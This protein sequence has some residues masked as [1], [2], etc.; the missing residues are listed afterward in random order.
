MASYSSTTIVGH[1]GKDPE[2]R[3]TQNGQQ[4]ANFSVAV[5]HKVGDTEHTIWY[6]VACWGKL[7]ET[8]E[9]YLRKGNPVMVNGQL[10][11]REYTNR[12][13]QKGFSV[14]VT[15]RDLVLLGN[16]QDSENGGG[17]QQAAQPQ[18][19]PHLQK[20]QQ[21]EWTVADKEDDMPF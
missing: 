16:R 6:N 7:A 15:C 21:E 8:A 10:S 19:A 12:D 2:M 1:L 11:I 20:A 17:Q 3:T 4:V 18:Q 9:K 13:G 5:S 14:D